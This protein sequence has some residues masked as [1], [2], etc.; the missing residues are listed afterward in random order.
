MCDYSMFH[1]KWRREQEQGRGR[2]ERERGRGRED[3]GRGR[4]REREEQERQGAAPEQGQE[5]ERRQEQHATTRIQSTISPW[6]TRLRSGRCQSR[7]SNSAM[8]PGAPLSSKLTT[9][10]TTPRHGPRQQPPQPTHTDGDTPRLRPPILGLPLASPRDTSG[11]DCGTLREGDANGP[12]ENVVHPSGS[13]SGQRS[14]PPE[15]PAPAPF[16]PPHQLPQVE[17][18]LPHPQTTDRGDSGQMRI[19]SEPILGLPLASPRDTSGH[20]CGTLREGDAHGPGENVV[21][22]SGSG[23]GQ[24]FPPPE[25]PAPA[26]FPPPHRLPQERPLPHPQT[27]TTNTNQTE[28]QYTQPTSDLDDNLLNRGGGQPVREYSLTIFLSCMDLDF[29]RSRSQTS[30]D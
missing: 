27:T 17:R 15:L 3:Q 30:F 5:Q 24:R 7:Q 23:S 14:P 16:P 6:C 4:E 8:P 28:S 20:D 29:P 11:H 10:V 22:P 2:E 13:G 26:P 21:R 25:L 12:G 1:T 9:S 19:P 18:P